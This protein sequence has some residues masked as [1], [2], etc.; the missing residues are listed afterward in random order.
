[1]LKPVQGP[2]DPQ[3]NWSTDFISVLVPS[4]VRPLPKDALRALLR[5]LVA[6][7]G[8]IVRGD[9]LTILP[10]RLT[11]QSTTTCTCTMLPRLSDNNAGMRHGHVGLAHPLQLADHHLECGFEPV[12]G[13]HGQVLREVE[14]PHGKSS[15]DPKSSLLFSHNSSIGYIMSLLCCCARSALAYYSHIMN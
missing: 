2:R 15:F 14:S 7:K 12:T 3:T 11:C 13:D 5:A 4:V 9:I 10:P 1:M 8:C 6:W